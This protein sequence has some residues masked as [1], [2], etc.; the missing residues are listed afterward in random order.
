MHV[1]RRFTGQG[2]PVAY[3]LQLAQPE[4]YPEVGSSVTISSSTNAYPNGERNIKK[5]GIL[6]P[7]RELLCAS[8]LR[9][10]V[11]LSVDAPYRVVIRTSAMGGVEASIF[12]VL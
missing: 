10:V 2:S 12:L 1:R 6:E 8:P 5:Q 9:M 11:C 3:C 7:Q 4:M